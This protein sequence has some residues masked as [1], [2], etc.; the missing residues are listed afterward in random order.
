MRLSTHSKCEVRA[1]CRDQARS[2]KA[3]TC[4]NAR[5]WTAGV[6]LQLHARLMFAINA[7]VVFFRHLA[8]IGPR[9]AIVKV[10]MSV[11]KGW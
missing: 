8:D 10:F 11:L 1:S 6:Y 7:A 9:G 3:E 2:A 4:Y 5:M